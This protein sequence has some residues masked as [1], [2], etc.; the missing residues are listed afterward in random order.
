MYRHRLEVHKF[1]ACSNITTPPMPHRNNASVRST[2]DE[3]ARSMLGLRRVVTADQQHMANDPS[4]IDTLSLPAGAAEH[5]H[6]TNRD[7]VRGGNTIKNGM[8]LTKYT[9]GRGCHMT[10]NPKPLYH[11]TVIDDSTNARED[12]SN[13]SG[14]ATSGSA[15]VRVM[16]PE[17]LQQ[18]LANP[19]FSQAIYWAP[20]GKAWRILDRKLLETHV[21]PLYFKHAKS[22]SFMKQVNL[23]NFDRIKRAGPDY[24]FYTHEVSATAYAIAIN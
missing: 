20:H 2:E 8:H 21:L 1:P 19:I 6:D 14:G 23:W 11:C 22:K 17:K 16:F 12:S 4:R 18:I 9:A 5:Q 24:G 10:Q 15:S 13:S 3:A 7:K